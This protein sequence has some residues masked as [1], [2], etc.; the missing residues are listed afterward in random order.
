MQ[1]GK[2]MSAN[3]LDG[4]VIAKE[5]REEV[6]AEVAALKEKGISP[7]NGCHPVWG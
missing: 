6:K 2:E 4:K 3:L 7:K 5:I 1:G